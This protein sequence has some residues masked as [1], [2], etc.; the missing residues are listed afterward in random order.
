M[1]LDFT[2]SFGKSVQMLYLM[3]FRPVGAQ[4]YHAGGQTHTYRRTEGQADRQI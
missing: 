2:G 3:E 4:L 1:D